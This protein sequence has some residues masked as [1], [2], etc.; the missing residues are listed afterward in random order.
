MNLQSGKLTIG[1]VGLKGNVQQSF[2]C[3][4]SATD[5]WEVISHMVTPRCDCFSAA[6]ELPI[7]GRGKNERDRVS[8]E[9][10][11]LKF[12]C[13]PLAISQPEHWCC[14]SCNRDSLAPIEV[15]T[16]VCI[17]FAKFTCKSKVCACAH[18]HGVFL[19]HANMASVCA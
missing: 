15:S 12:L 13:I 19:L 9:S 11:N 18:V 7:G 1:G 14:C 8:V 10:Y 3:T 2:T 5:S 6:L 4:N 17:N 16:A